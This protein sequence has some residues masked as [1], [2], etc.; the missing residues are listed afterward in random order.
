MIIN[1]LE[2]RWKKIFLFRHCQG[3]VWFQFEE[4]EKWGEGREIMA[5]GFEKGV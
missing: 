4:E 3:R 5:M 1:M 2:M